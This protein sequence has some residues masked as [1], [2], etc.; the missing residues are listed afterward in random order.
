MKYQVVQVPRRWVS[1]RGPVPREPVPEPVPRGPVPEPVPRGPA[2]EQ[3]AGPAPPASVLLAL[4]LLVV[5]VIGPS[6]ER[7]DQELSNDIKFIKI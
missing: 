5:H 7:G 1:A 6:S 3:A 4:V 2:P